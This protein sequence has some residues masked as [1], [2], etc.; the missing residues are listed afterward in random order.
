MEQERK[1][2]QCGQV[3]P[4]S[5]FKHHRGKALGYDYKCRTCRLMNQWALRIEA[6]QKLGGKCMYLGC[7]VTDPRLLQFHH[8]NGGGNREDDSR[9]RNR[10]KLYREII[11]GLRTDIDLLCSNHN[12]LREYEE[13]RRFN[14]V[15]IHEKP[16]D[17]KWASGSLPEPATPGKRLNRV[18]LER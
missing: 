4:L 12:T 14:P 8:K 15:L 3:K 7:E 9:N 10:P 13:G 11:S 5:D 1:C 18:C 16:E 17:A 2:T 6:Q